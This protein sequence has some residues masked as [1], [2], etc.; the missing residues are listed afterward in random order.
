MRVLTSAFSGFALLAS[1][2]ASLAVVEAPPEPAR[3][4]RGAWVASVYN[5]NWPSKPGLSANVQQAELRALLDRAV[6]LRLNA[7]LLQVRPA[8][9]A[10][11]ASKLEPWS[12]VLT[13][14]MGRDPGYDP[15][16]FAIQEAHARGL[17]L[18]AWFNP[19]RAATSLTAAAA[20]NHVTQA[21]PGWIRRYGTQLIVDPGE[22]E[23]RAYVRSVIMDVI[24]RYD[25]DGVHIDDYFYPYPVR[26]KSGAV[27]PFPDEATFAKYHGAQARDDWR[28]DN[29]NNFVETLYRSIKAEKRWVKFGI[30]PFGIWRPKV[31]E[32]TDA[33]LDAYAQLSADSRKWLMQGWCD[34]FS[35]QLY[36]S[37]DPPAQS[38]PVLLD[39]WRAQ[40]TQGRH[41]W[42]G[43]AD[44]RIGASRPAS[45]IIRQL[46]LTRAGA[47]HWEMKSLLENRGGIAAALQ[48]GPYAAG[49][50]VP[51]SP[52]LGSDPPRQPT[53]TREGT[54]ILWKPTGEIPARWWV[55]QS[56]RGGVWTLAVHPASLH[57][58]PVTEDLQEVAIRALD[59]F[60][61]TS[62]PALLTP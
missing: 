42:P 14:K 32:S 2:F 41:L 44:D 30:S 27:T 56:R 5:L 22:P 10:L 23:A 45:E 20:P 38:F 46:A 17:E 48:H 13:G 15:L 33:K 6:E 21:H 26:E 36:W 28:R 40:N 53:I 58:L 35:P 39:W 37:I 3:E 62:P 34:Y 50:L 1:S 25:L 57:A 11:Y 60:G 29:I 51:A 55:V 47:V 19:F 31:P 24:S 59:R 12:S 16:G 18:H 49:A 54:N 7:I 61:N 9:D 52:W 43:V 8:S 4:F